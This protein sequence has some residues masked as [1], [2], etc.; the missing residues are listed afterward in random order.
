MKG[1]SSFVS[2]IERENKLYVDEKHPSPDAYYPVSVPKYMIR[3]R[4]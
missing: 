1:V 4:I 2:N 3:G